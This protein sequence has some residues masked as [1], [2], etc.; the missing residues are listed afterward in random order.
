MTFETI[1]EQFLPNGL[2]DSRIEEIKMDY[3]HAC[4]TI[5]LLH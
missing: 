3:G 5:R 4:L 2:H 1:K